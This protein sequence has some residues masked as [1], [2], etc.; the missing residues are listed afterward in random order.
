MR[1]PLIR[2]QRRLE[3]QEPPPSLQ[4][5]DRTQVA[6]KIMTSVG[7]TCDLGTSDHIFLSRP[8]QSLLIVRHCISLPSSSHGVLGFWGFG[9]LGF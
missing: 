1:Q 6:M 2:L 3:L 8:L 9:V 7:G 5:H 4:P